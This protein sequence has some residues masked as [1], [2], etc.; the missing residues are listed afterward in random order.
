[1]IRKNQKITEEGPRR[2]G[3]GEVRM[4]ICI[5]IGELLRS[6]CVNYEMKLKWTRDSERIV[7]RNSKN[8]Q[9]IGLIGVEG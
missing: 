5:W 3:M 2:K 7:R 6:F 8:Q 4:K 1:M 9:V